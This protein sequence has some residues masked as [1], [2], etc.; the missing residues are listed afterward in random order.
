M[1]ISTP[2]AAYWLVNEDVKDMVFPE[3]MKQES[4]IITSEQYNVVIQ[5]LDCAAKQ[6]SV[7][8]HDVARVGFVQQDFFGRYE[9]YISTTNEGAV[10]IG[11]IDRQLIQ[12]PLTLE[13]GIFVIGVNEG[14][15]REAARLL[16]LPLE[17]MVV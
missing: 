3:A 1:T 11:K 7:G 10:F 15:V 2:P 14:S 6:A 16:K 9:A 4:N 5:A 13:R 12:E 8:S 17:K